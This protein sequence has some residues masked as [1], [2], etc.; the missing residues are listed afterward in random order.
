M[1]ALTFKG[2]FLIHIVVV[3]SMTTTSVQAHL[4]SAQKGTLNFTSNGA[5]IALSAPVSAFTG[6][7]ENKDGVLS[8]GEM[9]MHSEKIKQQIKQ[10]VQML[11]ASGEPLLLRGILIAS[12]H[13]N[14]NMLD[15]HQ[16][17]TIL[18]RFVVT[19]SNF[20]AG[21]RVTLYGESKEAESINVIVMRNGKSQK[22][23]FTVNDYY[24]TLFPKFTATIDN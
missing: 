17:I 8:R 14:D 11:D 18:G 10:R 4:M 21:L 16:Q 19:D 1:I 23:K 6:V 20:P 9:I 22:M 5:Y 3:L 7:D 15:L 2:L 24:H 12:S 13:P